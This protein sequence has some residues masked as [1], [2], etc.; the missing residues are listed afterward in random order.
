M[1]K[2]LLWCSIL[3]S[4]VSSHAQEELE[5]IAEAEQKQFCLTHQRSD[6]AGA[7]NNS[8]IIYQRMELFLDPAVHY[9]SG[10]ITSHFI[11]RQSIAYIEFD[12]SDSLQVDSVLYHGS[13]AS[14]IRSAEDIV[15]ILLPNNVAAGVTDSI[16]VYY[17]GAPPSSGFGSFATE[18][19]DS[20]PV[21]WTLS[22]PFGAKDWWPCRQNLS[23]KI[24][25]LDV[26]ITTPSNYYAV[27]NGVLTNESMIDTFKVFHWKHRYPIATYLIAVAVT[28][29][30]I[31]TDYVPRQNDSLAVVNYVYPEKLA[32]SQEQTQRLIPMMQLFE[33]LF[34]EY[35]Y[36]NEKY[37]HAQFN[38]GGGMEHQT[39]SFMGGFGFELMAHELAHQW[40]GDK[41]TCASWAD[42]WLNEGFA[43]YLSGLCYERI[44]PE[45]WLAFRRSRINA[46]VAE[47]EGS[48][49]CDDTTLVSRI[50]N[51]RLSYAKGAMV[52]HS[53]RWVLGDSL[54]FKG[55]RN[56]IDDVKFA[57]SF[58]TTGDFQQ[59]ME[60]V[61]DRNLQ[62][63]FNDWIYG[64]GFPSYR[65]EWQQNFDGLVN[66]TIHQEQ[67]HPSVSFFDIPVDLS[68][69]GPSGDTTIIFHP[70]AS[71]TSYSFTLPFLADS[72]VF[73]PGW[74][75]ISA[76]NVVW[77]QAAYDFSMLIYPNPVTG[78][79]HLRLESDEYRDA[80]VSIF[81]RMGQKVFSGN[82]EVLKGS[83]LLQIETSSW[84]GGVYFIR[85]KTKDR[86]TLTDTFVKLK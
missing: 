75:I 36:N 5:K 48:V 23:D 61:S 33:D 54:F 1:R 49:W 25:S 69:H 82:H 73:D 42:I 51:S 79:L 28:N 10:A 63:F 17:S 18:F 32:E 78:L 62:E 76:N 83:H 67:S 56:Y 85:L 81:N 11:A 77:R 15:Q 58:A 80:E 60:A 64:K 8:D 50:F 27:S 16:T 84:N 55:L 45:W 30:A 41:I 12:I 14:F 7:E 71:G 29:Y 57:Y 35:P 40:F 59:H 22:Q 9:V 43:T 2:W 13:P 24:D 52:L 44:L 19:H 68:F 34:G 31:Y 26:I 47:P 72:I 46:S 66:L 21:L 20:V 4:A 53:L 38:W 74:W 6:R 86:K 65:V 39:V 37:G 70:T 3:C